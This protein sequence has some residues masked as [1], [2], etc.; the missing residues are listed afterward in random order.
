MAI[1]AIVLLQEIYFLS[2]NTELI[3]AL[4]SYN[5]IFV[6]SDNLINVFKFLSVALPPGST[7]DLW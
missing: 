2:L 3:S 4:C 1:I 7:P 6:F 5:R